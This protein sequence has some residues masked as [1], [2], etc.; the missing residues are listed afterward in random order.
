M[1]ELALGAPSSSRA[2]SPR[3]EDE[4]AD[5]LGAQLQLLRTARA[6]LEAGRLEQAAEAL[7]SYEDR[8]PEGVIGPQIAGLRRELRERSAERAP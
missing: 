3:A 6:N 1:S 8:F 5:W 2:E 4:S 7:D